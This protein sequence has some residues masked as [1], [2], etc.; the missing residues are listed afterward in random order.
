MQEV[1]KI[2]LYHSLDF[3]NKEKRSIPLAWN[4]NNDEK[5]ATFLPWMTSLNP[6]HNCFQNAEE[7]PNGLKQRGVLLVINKR[8]SSRQLTKDATDKLLSAS[9]QA[10]SSAP[11]IISLTKRWKKMQIR[12]QRGGPAIKT[13]ILRTFTRKNLEAPKL[14]RFF[15]KLF[16][17]NA[18][19]QFFFNSV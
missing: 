9:I 5:V 19:L 3:E 14:R 7:T 13:G 4:K 16:K 17:E 11:E 1:N 2:H 18:D 8:F 6:R 10:Y 15:V 12:K